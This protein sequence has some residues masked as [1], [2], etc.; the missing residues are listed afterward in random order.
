MKLKELRE[1]RGL[2]LSQVAQAA[3]VTRAAVCMWES[4]ARQPGL[5][6]L[7]ALADLYGV[8]LDAL[9]GRTPPGQDAS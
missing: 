4:G 5:D 9:C 2:T 8:S 7:L 3:H 1:A 6:S